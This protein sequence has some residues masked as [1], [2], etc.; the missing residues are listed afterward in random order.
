M[1]RPAYSSPAVECGDAGFTLMELLVALVLIALMLALM[2]D[3]MLLARQAWQ[4][5]ERLEKAH[6]VDAGLDFLTNR[7]EVAQPLYHRTADAR[8]AVTFSGTNNKVSFVAPMPMSAPR[9]GLYHF[10]AHLEEVGGK[11]RNLVV[12]YRIH[13]DSSEGLE[14]TERKTL[15][16][17]VSRFSLRYF[18]ATGPENSEAAWQSVWQ[19]EARLPHLIELK[20]STGKGAAT[21]SRSVIVTPRLRRD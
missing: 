10:D 4:G 12:G 6:E 16:R 15:I 1:K 9:S 20:I 11:T 7:L 17:D 8:R 21:R 3:A 19:E 13:S 14:P 18:S 2:P 5:E